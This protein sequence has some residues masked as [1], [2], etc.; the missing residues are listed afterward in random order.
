VGAVVDTTKMPA[1]TVDGGVFW[2]KA[3]AAPTVVPDNTGNQ[4]YVDPTTLALCAYE[5]G[6]TLHHITAYDK[7]LAASP[8]AAAVTIKTPTARFK[9]TANSIA[10]IATILSADIPSKSVGSALVEIEGR[11]TVD[12]TTFQAWRQVQWDKTGA[13][14][15]TV[16]SNT[17]GVDRGAIAGVTIDVST[18]IRIRVTP[19]KNDDIRWWVRVH[20]GNCTD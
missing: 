3:I 9:T 2:G 13:G 6:G 7:S 20:F 17:L 5:H 15:L 16:N 8:S 12:D 1:G 10:T 18:D 4:F 14:T 11:D 19:T